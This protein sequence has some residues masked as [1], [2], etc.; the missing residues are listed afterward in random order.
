[1]K[2]HEELSNP[3]SCLSKAAHD[4]P[5]FILRA[6][7]KSAPVAIRAWI[8]ERIASGQNTRSDE[9]M[10]SAAALAEEMEAYSKA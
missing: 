3:K 8:E 4:E 10:I 2:K 6:T 9:K 5:L 1:M 7:D